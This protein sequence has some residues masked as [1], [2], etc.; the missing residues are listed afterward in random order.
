MED[1]SKING[2]P[3]Y[4]SDDGKIGSIS[5][6]LMKPESKTIDRF[7]VGEGGVLGVGTHYVA[8]PINA[9]SWDSQRGGF[10]LAKTADDLKAMPEWKQQVAEAPDTG[11]ADAPRSSGGAIGS[12][13]GPANTVPQPDAGERAPTR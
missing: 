5:T 11:A 8:L 4:G 2:A 6:V 13:A 7:V 12:G 1:I 9:F 3:V 10:R